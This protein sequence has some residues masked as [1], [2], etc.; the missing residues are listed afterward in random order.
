M[1]LTLHKFRSKRAPTFQRAWDRLRA[2]PRSP[3]DLA[4]TN[5]RL[6]QVEALA[7]TLSAALAVA[8]RDVDRD[9][10]DRLDM[11]PRELALYELK[12]VPGIADTRAQ[13]LLSRFGSLVAIYDASVYE[14]IEHVPSVGVVLAER[15]K[16]HLR[17][18]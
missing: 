12:R 8:T 18:L 14:I 5:L 6:E 15:V 7:K 10:R 3:L 11:L 17:S 13:A 9:Q 1:H 2:T 16:D 4:T